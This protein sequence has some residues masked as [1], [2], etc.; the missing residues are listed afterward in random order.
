MSKGLPA[1]IGRGKTIGAV[2]TR[3]EGAAGIPGS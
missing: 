3:E 2:G 1:K